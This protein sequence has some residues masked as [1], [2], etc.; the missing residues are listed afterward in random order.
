[1][2][3]RKRYAYDNSGNSYRNNHHRHNTNNTVSNSNSNYEIPGFY[4]DE[5]KKRYFKIQ[6]N[7]QTNL[8][9]NDLIKIKK[10]EHDLSK[11]L[12]KMKPTSLIKN[13]L[14]NLE[15][16]VLNNKTLYSERDNYIVSNSKCQSQINFELD[17]KIRESFLI[18]SNSDY[19]HLLC[20]CRNSIELLKVYKT[21]D[22]FSNSKIENLLTNTGSPSFSYFSVQDNKYLIR[23]IDRP[24]GVILFSILTKPN[25][26]N[27]L[28]EADLCDRLTF[29]HFLNGKDLWCLRLNSCFKTE[30]KLSKFSIGFDDHAE[31]VSLD[32]QKTVLYVNTLNSGVFSQQFH[33]IVSYKIKKITTTFN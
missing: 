5:E 8:V 3:N 29:E 11:N 13:I 22:K 26:E 4:Y 33:P 10:R 7:H 16:G 31:V 21:V 27:N 15:L 28:N 6:P 9:T 30:K 18:N 12:K 24:L 32:R 17:E 1:M 25:A 20:N 2:N 19:V 23:M 14:L